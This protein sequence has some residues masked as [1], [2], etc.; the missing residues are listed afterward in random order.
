MNFTTTNGLAANNIRS[1]AWDARGRLWVGTANGLTILEGTNPV[2][3]TANSTSLKNLVPGGPDGSLVGNARIATALRPAAAAGR[4]RLPANARVLEFDGTNSYVE[5]P[6]DIFNGLEEA[7]VEGWVKWESFG[8]ADSMFFCFGGKGEA[9]FVCNHKSS[10]ALKFV[11]YDANG[12]R[13]GWRCPIRLQR[14]CA[15]PARA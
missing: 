10:P 7:T 12:Q 3:F 6:P 11:I 2:P 9:M 1:L 14:Q 13:H 15:R 4:A 8:P 5:L